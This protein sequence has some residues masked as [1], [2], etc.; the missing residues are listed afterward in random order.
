MTR[1]HLSV[2][3]CVVLLGT[4]CLA[5]AG[6]DD[7]PLI[8]LNTGDVY[9]LVFSGDGTRLV[10][11]TLTQLTIWN[12]TTG[13]AVLSEDFEHGYYPIALTSD[14]GAIGAAHGDQI[15]LY[16]A[17]SGVHLRNIPVSNTHPLAFAFSP[18]GTTLAID[19][20]HE[21]TVQFLHVES[22]NEFDRVR[23]DDGNGINSFA[24]APDGS[25]L[26]VAYFYGE[27]I[28]GPG[29]GM[30]MYFVTER[31]ALVSLP[32]K[33][34][35][36]SYSNNYYKHIAYSPDGSLYAVIPGDVHVHDAA[37]FSLIS[38]V[39][40]PHSRV[41]PALAFSPEGTKLLYGPRLHDAQTGELL[42]E[43]PLYWY[44]NKVAYSPDGN[45][46]AIENHSNDT[47]TIWDVSDLNTAVQD[48]PEREQ[49]VRRVDGVK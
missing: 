44:D 2:A 31:A 20:R 17:E 27:T 23:F 26:L 24:F 49:K 7:E 43:F 47:V 29:G 39:S 38:E 19:V 30:T 32:G 10:S 45:K 5:V 18:D 42:R 48:W 37:T 33:E 35:L 14:G 15:R 36:A 12:V 4:I 21:A 34:I 13:E 9:G 25:Q 1:P 11:R 16:D 28:G 6:Q 41:P 40:T 22:G 3:I 46:V 8:T